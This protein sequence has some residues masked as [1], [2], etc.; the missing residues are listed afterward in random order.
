[1]LKL[2]ISRLLLL[3]GMI[4]TLGL[5]SSIGVQ[6]FAMRYLKVGGPVYTEIANGKDL[7]ADILPPPLYVIEAYMLA[8][9]ALLYPELADVNRTKTKDLRASFEDRKGF[10]KTARLDETLRAKLEN[11]V[12]TTGETFWAALDAYEA[13][14][15]KG[16]APSLDAVQHAFYDHDAKVRELASQATT[17]LEGSVAQAE[18]S[19]I[20]YAVATSVGSAVS[21]LI[22]LVGLWFVRRRAITPLVEIGAYM[23]ILS[24][25]TYSQE[26]PLIERDDE[27]GSVARSVAV[28]RA[29]AIERQ[30]MQ[31]TV[32][33]EQ[34]LSQERLAEQQ[35]LREREDEELQV[36]V[37]TLGAALER[38]AQC[39]IRMT[40]DEPFAERFDLLRRDFN[41]SITTF[42]ETLEQVLGKTA[43]LSRSA[44]SMQE[45]AE[46]LSQR[47]EQQEAALEK[48]SAALEEVSVTV[49]SS[50]ERA[51]ET[52]KLVSAANECATSSGQI[53][54]DAV[55]AMRRIEG[56]SMQIGQIIHVIDE[57]AFQTNLLALNAGVEAA[58]AGEAGKGF[59]VVAQEV[60]ELAQR[61]AKAA[62]DITAL[63]K[64]SSDEVQNGVRLV[65]QTGAA[66]D[67]IT[68]FVVEIDEKVDV[69]TIAAREQTT[70][71]QQ[72]SDAVNALDHMTQQNAAMVGE[73]TAISRSLFADASDL[74]ELAAR[75]KLNRR[76]AVREPGTPS[77]NQAA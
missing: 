69:I 18:Q 10:W 31:L 39:N 20:F 74:N 72:I 12:V 1:M 68:R 73:T 15:S 63:V 45:A 64:A 37:Q 43:T 57:I 62:K 19:S 48:T 9:E 26:V 2:T 46:E 51:G 35:R 11:E 36:V 30:Q 56:S 8:N 6:T 33:R 34:A 55:D 65:D 71:L 4:V 52:R 47:T 22:F 40:L 7:I 75:F 58:R 61:S 23:S 76:K 54:R 41:N 29:A 14:L 5:A 13:A 66:L 77:L 38:L 25:G 3:F 32:E 28:F 59:A 44:S 53:V 24:H 16:E 60:R 17:T 67:Q 50:A 49:H 70:G 42:Q 27:I 21:V